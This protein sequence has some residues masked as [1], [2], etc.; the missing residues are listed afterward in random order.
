MT[1]WR[2]KDRGHGPSSGAQEAQRELAEAQRRLRETHAAGSE[3]HSLAEQLRK[4]RE[5]NNF[6][7]MIAA[8][9]REHR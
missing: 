3:I 6:A 7:P 4:I 1:W 5:R 2:R 8:A 9:F